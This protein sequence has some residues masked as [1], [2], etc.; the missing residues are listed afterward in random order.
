MHQD[1]KMSDVAVTFSIYSE[2]LLKQLLKKFVV[3]EKTTETF[4]PDH[5][6]LYIKTPNFK[7]AFKK[8][9]KDVFEFRFSNWNQ[10][11]R[12][13]VPNYF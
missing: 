6:F 1:N 11:F 3:N 7:K 4:F 8:L 12:N 13:W 9:L 5:T 10:K 2:S